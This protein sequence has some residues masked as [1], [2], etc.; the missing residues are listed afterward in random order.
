MTAGSA[1]PLFRSVDANESPLQLNE[2][3]LAQAVEEHSE[4]DDRRQDHRLE[5]EVDLSED[6]ARLDHLHQDRSD[7]GAERRSDAS[8]QTGSAKDCRGDHIEFLANP[9]RLIE[10]PDKGDEGEAAER[11]ADAGDHIDEE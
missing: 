9:E 8:E 4:E 2:A 6:H 1:D 11:G 7:H 5:V 3:P 10:A